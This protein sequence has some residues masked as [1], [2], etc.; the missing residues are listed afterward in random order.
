MFDQVVFAGGGGRCTWQ[1]G[2][3]SLLPVKLGYRR[4]G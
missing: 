3:G 4:G 1:I 2:F